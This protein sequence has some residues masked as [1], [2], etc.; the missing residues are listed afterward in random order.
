MLAVRPRRPALSGHVRRQASRGRP[1]PEPSDPARAGRRTL[2]R[3]APRTAGAAA[4]RAVRRS[5]RARSRRQLDV[6]VRGCRRRLEAGDQSRRARRRSARLDGTADPARAAA[7]TIRPSAISASRAADENAHAEVEQVGRRHR[8]PRSARERVH[9]GAGEAARRDS[10]VIVTPLRISADPAT[11]HNDSRSP[12][13]IVP[14]TTAIIGVNTA[15][16]L[17]DVESQLLS[18]DTYIRKA[19]TLPTIER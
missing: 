1:W 15:K 7:R 8:R 19:R 13:T 9:T 4:V 3:P 10:S 16:K 2:R 14:R 17:T 18:S 6:S 11:L 12:R 5:P